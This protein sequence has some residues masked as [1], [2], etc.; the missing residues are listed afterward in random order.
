[1][2]TTIRPAEVHRLEVYDI[3]G[4][5]PWEMLLVGYFQ[6]FSVFRQPIASHFEVFTVRSWNDTSSVN[7]HVYSC[8]M[9]RPLCIGDKTLSSCYRISLLPF[10]FVSQLFLVSFKTR[11]HTF[12]CFSRRSGEKRLSPVWTRFVYL[13]SFVL[14]AL[15]RVAIENT[16]S[17]LMFKTFFA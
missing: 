3:S 6:N 4:N 12:S 2:Y 17:G 1:M 11:C 16:F 13:S 10:L 7:R 9:F 8:K 5:G 15:W 14:I